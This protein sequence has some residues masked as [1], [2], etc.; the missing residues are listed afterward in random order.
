M[1]LS[2][3]A[4]AMELEEA[5]GTFPFGLLVPEKIGPVIDWP[6]DKEFYTQVSKTDWPAVLAVIQED[7]E[8][9]GG[10]F[11]PKLKLQ[12]YCEQGSFVGV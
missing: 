11:D 3:A 12:R 9:Y 8:A 2:K 5:K 4:K 1:G 10:V 6:E 7:K